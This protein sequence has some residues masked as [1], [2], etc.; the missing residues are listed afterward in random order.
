MPPGERAEYSDPGFILLG[1]ALE[2][3]MREP[4][5]D[6]TRREIFHR[7]ELSA[8]GFNPYRYLAA[9]IPPTEID[10]TFRNRVIQG[11]VQDENAWVLGGVSGHAG[12]FSSVPDL[13]RFSEEVL[14]TVRNPQSNPVAGHLFSAATVER[15]AERQPPEGSSRALGWDTPSPQSSSGRHFSSRSIGHLGFSGC[16]LWIDLD[17]DIAVVLL[18]NRSWPDRR[19]QAIKTVRPAFHDA[20]RE[21]L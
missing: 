13:L 14:S 19:N 4:L 17:A 16:S 3:L 20:V 8:T 21:A 5:A 12:L 10:S 11:E 1:K 18:T 6:W 2:V 7:L 15:F 9:E